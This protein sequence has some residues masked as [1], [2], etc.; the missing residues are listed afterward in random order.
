MRAVQRR[1]ADGDPAATLAFDVYCR[2]I[3]EY[4]GAYLAVL[5]RV[6]AITFRTTVS[7]RTV[8]ARQYKPNLMLIHVIALDDALECLSSIDPRK[9]RM[10]DFGDL[11]WNAEHELACPKNLIGTGPLSANSNPVTPRTLNTSTL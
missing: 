1:R 6:D 4:V 11:T 3:K 10:V 7:A 5:G 9:G 2:R 8:V